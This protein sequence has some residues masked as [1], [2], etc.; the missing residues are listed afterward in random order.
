MPPVRPAPFRSIIMPAPVRTGTLS[1]A[2]LLA[3]TN[4]SV[5]SYGYE[6]V[7]TTLQEELTAH[8]AVVTDMVE[9]LAVRTTDRLVGIGGDTN[10]EMYETDEFA[11]VPTQK[12]EG[13]TG[14]GI[15]LGEFQ[16]ATGHTDSFETKMSPADVAKRTIAVEKGHIRALYRGVANALLIPTNRQ[17]EDYTVDNTVLD[18]KALANGDG[19]FIGV[20]PN[21]E[22]FDRNTHSHYLAID[23]AAST[24]AQRAFAVQSVIGTVI[25]HT[26]GEGVRLVV[27]R[28][29]EQKVRDLPGFNAYADPRVNPTPGM[30]TATTSPYK[31]NNRPIGFMGGAEVWV[32]PWA[33]PGY[34]V[35]H[36]TEG[37]KPLAYRE[38]AMGTKGLYLAASLSAYPLNAQYYK[39]QFG[40]GVRNRVAAAALYI[41]GTVYV[42]PSVTAL[43]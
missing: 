17:V 31:Q 2:D 27:A 29:D 34:M 38:P 8:N 42:A 7:A 3:V 12:S 20:G 30:A 9:S 24:A 36:D 16:T 21:G 28:A 19:F 40:F 35:V 25:E 13:N 32:K 33:V 1:I 23:W 41:G 43:F 39:A 22:S 4:M 6:Q 14:L 37:P 18:V 10:A 5:A 15:P 11:R 26:E